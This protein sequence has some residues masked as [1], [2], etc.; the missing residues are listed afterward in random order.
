[1]FLIMIYI[2]YHDVFVGGAVILDG[3]GQLSEFAVN[4]FVSFIN[5]LSNKFLEWPC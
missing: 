2:A 3:A 1:M 4:S 5:K